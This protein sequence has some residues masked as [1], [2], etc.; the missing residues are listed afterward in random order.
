M[1]KV[2]QVSMFYVPIAGGQETY[3]SNLHHILEKNSYT[4][5][6]IQLQ[7]SFDKISHVK[8]IPYIPKVLRK[9]VTDADWFQFNFGLQLS[10]NFLSK[11]DLLICHYPFHYPILSWHKN[12]I[13]LSHGVDWMNPPRTLADKYR[14]HALQICHRERP[15][16]VAND[17]H[18]LRNL[19][20]DIQPA[21]CEFQQVEQN[22]FYIPNCVDT[23]D[24]KPSGLERKNI[25][26]LPRNIRRVRGIHLAI[27]AFHLFTKKCGDYQMWIAG[28][29]LKG[30]YYI[31]C[32]KLVEDLNMQD[33]V[34]FL[35]SIPWK[36][37]VD[38]YNQVKLTLIPTIEL[39]GTSLSALESMAC[40]T[41]VVST[42]VGGLKDIPTIKAFVE[43]SSIAEAMFKTLENWD[44][45]SKSQYESVLRTFNLA[46]WEDTW[47]N[48]I[49]T[50]LNK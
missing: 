49:R 18:F 17:T 40:G 13:V 48:V 21:S 42:D 1:L 38:Y 34:F 23:N 46:K 29:G 3:I 9:I 47:L 39:E 35:G 45:Y 7:R 16:I 20:L 37:L 10:K 31:E 8:K 28:G 33:K 41:P 26:L 30:S 12:V 43:P 32:K 14:V 44:F 2:M 27:Q 25:I 6:V 22:I 24:F 50:K 15:T 5:Q 11:Y 19:G 36:S 4:S